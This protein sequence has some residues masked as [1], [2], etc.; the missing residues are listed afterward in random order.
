MC[1]RSVESKGKAAS[2][3][4]SAVTNHLQSAIRDKAKY[5]FI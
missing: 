3:G 1:G 2:M 5:T 4:F